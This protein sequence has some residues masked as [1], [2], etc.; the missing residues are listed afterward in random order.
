MQS[1]KKHQQ[2][3]SCAKEMTKGDNEENKFSRH[4]SDEVLICKIC[5]E[6]DK[7]TTREKIS[8]KMSKRPK[9]TILGK[10]KNHLY[11]WQSGKY[12]NSQHQ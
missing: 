8:L 9:Y 5:K 1:L 7:S 2:Q 4:I 3:K 10:R 11:K 6:S 12:K